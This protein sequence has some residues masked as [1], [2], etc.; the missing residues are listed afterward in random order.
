MNFNP[1]RLVKSF[2]QRV[3]WKLWSP[4]SDCKLDRPIFMI[5]CPRSG[6]SIVAKM[7]GIH[8]NLAHWSEAVQV[9][10]PEYYNNNNS[11]NHIWDQTDLTEHDKLRIKA[12]FHL[13]QIIHVKSRFLNKHPRNSLRIKYIQEIFPDCRFIHVIRNPIAIVESLM[14]KSQELD[15]LNYAY[16]RFCKPPNWRQYIDKPPEIMHS[17]QWKEIVEYIINEAKNLGDV[18]ITL[19]YEDLC[20]SPEREI[21]R[22]CNFAELDFSR[23]PNNRLLESKLENM[24]SKAWKNLK[25]DEIQ[26]I[27]NIVYNTAQKLGYEIS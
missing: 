6:T 7:L 26:K 3:G 10:D 18:Y 20:E 22:L 14:R 15:R 21:E 25:G 5:G 12:T 1:D 11:K 17:F 24:N 23:Y 16:G 8:P 19:R 4:I 2:C 13:Y 9:W 27:K